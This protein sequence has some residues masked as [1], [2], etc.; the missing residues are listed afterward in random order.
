METIIA[1]W[2][3]QI[4]VLATIIAAWAAFRSEVRQRLSTL[5]EKVKTLYTLWNNSRQR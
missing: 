1:D 4:M 5:E 3:P 2:W